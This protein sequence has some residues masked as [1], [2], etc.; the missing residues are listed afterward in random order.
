LRSINE[1][2]RRRAR[3][4]LR[5]VTVGRRVNYLRLSHHPGEVSLAIHVVKRNEYYG[6]T[7]YKSYKLYFPIYSIT[8][9]HYSR[10]SLY[11][12][13][14]CPA[15]QL[16][17]ILSY[18]ISLSQRSICDCNKKLSYRASDKGVYRHTGRCNSHLWSCGVNRVCQTAKKQLPGSKMW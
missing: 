13:Q 11:F 10:S 14:Y 2:N 12:P 3:L 18:F 6:G 1:V 16:S 9:S 15:W 4:V 5:R 8:G 7:R 17:V